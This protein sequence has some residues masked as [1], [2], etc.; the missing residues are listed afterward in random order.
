MRFYVTYTLTGA[1]NRITYQYR[2]EFCG[3]TD[4]NIFAQALIDRHYLN[5]TVG[6]II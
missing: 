6:E 3:I 2:A 5:V 4:A 1:T